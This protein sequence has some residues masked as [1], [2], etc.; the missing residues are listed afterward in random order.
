MVGGPELVRP[1]VHPVESV[2]PA[3]GEEYLPQG[4]EAVYPPYAVQPPV[5]PDGQT[6]DTALFP[7]AAQFSEA[8]QFSGPAQFSESAPIPEPRS[9]GQLVPYR[10]GGPVA[11]YAAGGGGVDRRSAVGP[12]TAGR[13]RRAALIG[14]GAL[15]VA[16]LGVAAALVPHLLGGGTVNEAMPQP[17]VTAPLPSSGSD[18]AS[19][20]V[21]PQAVSAHPSLTARPTASHTLVHRTAKPTP[22]SSAVASASPSRSGV[23]P[24]KSTASSSP[25]ATGPTSAAPGAGAQSLQLGDQ[26]PAVDTLQSQLRDLGITNRSPTGTFDQRTERDVEQ[27]QYWYNVQG[28]PAGVYGPNSQ[29]MMAS[30]QR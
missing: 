17:G 8:A 21:S 25:G 23:T 2:D 7:A 6:R 13:G 24:P 29:A 16:G 10:P 4:A 11:P 12:P 15:A 19:A 5:R 14:A 22:S 28:D 1:Y 20:S 18:A 30:L 27:F 3:E 26:G 9:G